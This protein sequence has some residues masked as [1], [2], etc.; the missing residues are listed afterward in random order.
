MAL[1][2]ARHDQLDETERDRRAELRQIAA[3]SPRQRFALLRFGAL[4]IALGE[5]DG[6]LFGPT[7]QGS[8]CGEKTTSDSVKPSATENG[9]VLEAEPVIEF[10]WNMG[11]MSGP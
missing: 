5:N 10:V 2:R 6:E 8:V 11:N 1:Q 7:D 4:G 3:K 9:L